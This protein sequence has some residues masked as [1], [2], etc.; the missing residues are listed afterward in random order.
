[1]GS[2]MRRFFLYE[3]EIGIAMNM[4]LTKILVNHD[5]A[6]NPAAEFSPQ[7][8]FDYEYLLDS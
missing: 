2:F 5:T 6:V 3:Q 4:T 7:V 1:M 8:L